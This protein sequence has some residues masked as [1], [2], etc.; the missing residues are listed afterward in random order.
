MKQLLAIFLVLASF[1]ASSQR[2]NEYLEQ[3]HYGNS[4]LFPDTVEWFNIQSGFQTY[5]YK[6]KIILLHFWD[7]NAADANMILD[8]VLS[9]RNARKEVIPVTIINPDIPQAASKDRIQRC[10]DQ[11]NINHPVAYF[12]DMSTLKPYELNAW[13]GYILLLT[14]GQLAIEQKIESTPGVVPQFVDSLVK[15]TQMYNSRYTGK[16]GIL[17]E[18]LVEQLLDRPTVLEIDQ[19]RKRFFVVDQQKNRVIVID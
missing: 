15:V 16:E 2:M 7:P 3:V 8:E 1:V 5:D 12:T 19:V 6:D 14:K 4:V 13:N 9:I 18:L 10:I 17:N 11:Y